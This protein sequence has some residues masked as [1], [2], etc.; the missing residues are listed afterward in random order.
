M[1]PPALV[2]G[3]QRRCSR[4]TSRRPLADGNDLPAWYWIRALKIV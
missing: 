3:K 1:R 4:V 2:V